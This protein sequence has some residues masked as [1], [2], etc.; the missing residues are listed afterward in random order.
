LT[1]E[2]KIEQLRQQTSTSGQSVEELQA[3]FQALKQQQQGGTATK[4]EEP[5]TVAASSVKAKGPETKVV[6]PQTTNSKPIEV[7]PQEVERFGQ[8]MQ[9][10]KGGDKAQAAKLSRE[11]KA[12]LGPEK[13]EALKQQYLASTQKGNA[14][15]GYQP[16]AGER[17][18]T[19]V[20]YK[21]QSSAQR[22]FPGKQ[23]FENC[24]PQSCQQIIKAAT[25]QHFSEAE[26]ERIAFD[27]TNYKPGKGTDY[28]QLPNI[29]NHVGVGSGL[30]LNNPENIRLALD[31]GLGVISNHDIHILW[32]DGE[33]AHAVHVTGFERDVNGNVTHYFIND[34]GDGVSGL[35]VKADKFESSLVP[36][37]DATIT[38]DPLSYGGKV[39]SETRR[40]NSP[41][42]AIDHFENSAASQKAKQSGYPAA[43][44]GY[45]WSLDKD[46][47]LRYDRN[48]KLLPDGAERPK[49]IYDPQTKTFVDRS[50]TD[51]IVG[52][53]SYEEI[54]A[55]I[56]EWQRT[57]KSDGSGHYTIRDLG[58]KGR[59]ITDAEVTPEFKASTHQIIGDVDAYIAAERAKGRTLKEIYP[60]VSGVLYRGNDP[61]LRDLCNKTQIAENLKDIEVIPEL[62]PLMQER[63]DMYQRKAKEIGFD[64]KDKELLGKDEPGRHAEFLAMNK[65]LLDMERRGVKINSTEELNNILQ[66]VIIYNGYVPR[67]EKLDGHRPGDSM[68]RCSNCQV[69]TDGAL[70]L[71]DLPLEFWRQ[72]FPEYETRI[73]NPTILNESKK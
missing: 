40:K 51:K 24:G 10:G 55:E 39:A 44:D 9:F 57:L 34:T 70:S 45:H 41:Q 19:Q 16:K 26:M 13:Y 27:T 3:K 52:A 35:R 2:E 48:T 73:N 23:N 66:D 69:L 60:D 65:L 71:S 47:K 11:L 20:E 25:G 38:Y 33:G 4:A 22:N 58:V 68:I 49:K 56:K 67:K 37:F 12:D 21:K 7:R 59:T 36:D 28:D 1:R 46:G 32:G 53:G 29:L 61:R 14:L 50:A 31:H 5:K 8:I 43:E 18:T 42:K 72:H 6:T 63:R 17:S 30:Y 54:P 15:K 62:H 64:P